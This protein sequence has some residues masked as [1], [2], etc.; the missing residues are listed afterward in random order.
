[1]LHAAIFDF[2]GTLTPLTLDFGH[3]RA[4]IESFAERYV[5]RSVIAAFND[6]YILEMIHS[7]ADVIGDDGPQFQKEAFR[8]LDILEIEACRGKEL[9]PYSREVLACLKRKNIHI[10]IIT[11]SCIEVIRAIFHDFQEYVEIIVTRDDTRFVK[12]DP[13]QLR[14]AVHGLGV[15]PGHTVIVGDHPTDVAA[16]IALGTITAGVLSGRCSRSDFIKAGAAYIFEDIR[17]LEELLQV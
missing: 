17:G 8:E 14:I 13:E 15:G 10:G 6:Q 9:Y 12:P 4:H 2:D 11:R 1:M 16:G 5:A 7:I 3:L